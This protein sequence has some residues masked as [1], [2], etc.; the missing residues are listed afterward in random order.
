MSST[1]LKANYEGLLI[2]L[3]GFRK[4]WK[5]RWFRLVG[6]RLSYYASR[7]SYLTGSSPKG[8]VDLT[9]ESQVH[10][11]VGSY[12]ADHKALQRLSSD[13]HPFLMALQ[14]GSRK[15]TYFLAASSAGESHSWLE[16]LRAQ[17]DLART[18]LSSSSSSPSSSS[19]SSSSSTSSSSEKRNLLDA[20][21]A[22]LLKIAKN[23]PGMV[24]L[25]WKL[26][27]AE[28]GQ[29]LAEALSTNTTLRNL[30]LHGRGLNDQACTAI[31]KKLPHCARL[32]FLQLY[33]GQY[34][35][36]GLVALARVL[37][38]LPALTCLDIDQSTSHAAIHDGI[39]ALANTL[40][41]NKQLTRLRL[42]AMG[43]SDA[44]VAVIGEAI[45]ENATL[46]QL[47]LSANPFGEAGLQQLASDLK[48]NTTLSSLSLNNI[49]GPLTQ[50]FCEMCHTIS[51][52]PHLRRF[53]FNQNGLSL[54]HCMQFSQM[55][56]SPAVYLSE[57]VLDDTNLQNDE[58]SL[59]FA[60]LHCNLTLRKLSLRKNNISS[61]AD[62]IDMIQHNGFLETLDLSENPIGQVAE[63]TQLGIVLPQ[64]HSLRSLIFEG[65]SLISQDAVAQVLAALDWNL[66]L[67]SFTIALTDPQW[68]KARI[69]EHKGHN[70]ALPLRLLVVP[71]SSA[72]HAIGVG[73]QLPL[74]VRRPVIDVSGVDRI[75]Q[76]NAA[77]DR[78]TLNPLVVSGPMSGGLVSNDNRNLV[79]RDGTILN[80]DRLPFSCGEVESMLQPYIQ[81]G[82]NRVKQISF[83]G[84]KQLRSVPESL[85]AYPQLLS[86]CLAQA[87]LTSFLSPL[88]RQ[89]PNLVYLDLR[90]NEILELGDDLQHATKLQKL[91]V[92]SNQLASLPECIFGLR[93]A[94]LGSFKTLSTRQN[95][96]KDPLLPILYDACVV[97]ELV[98]SGRDLICVPP[99]ILSML[100]LQVLDLSRNK[101]V[102]IPPA[103]GRLTNLS[104]LNLARNA[105][106]TLPWQLSHL[107]KLQELSLAKNPLEKLPGELRTMPTSHILAYLAAMEHGTEVNYRTKCIVVGNGNVGK[108]SLINALRLNFLVDDSDRR[109][110]FGRKKAS[111]ENLSREDISFHRSSAIKTIATDGVDI[112]SLNLTDSASEDH[113]E[114]LTYDFAGQEVYYSTHEFFMSENAVYLVAFNLLDD[115]AD[116]L[117]FITYWLSAVQTR[118][119]RAP[120]LIVGTHLDDERCTKESVLRQLD[121]L[122]AAFKSKFSHIAGYFP[123]SSADGRGIREISDR[124]VRVALTRPQMSKEMPR[125]FRVFEDQLHSLAL[126]RDPPLLSRAEF[127]TLASESGILHSQVPVL[128]SFLNL[129]G[130]VISFG[131]DC[132]FSE[133]KA[134]V[135]LNPQWL[136]Y[137]FRCLISLKQ[138]FVRKGILDHANL[139]HIFKP[140]HFPPQ[141]HPILMLLLT[142]FEIIVPFPE[143]NVKSLKSIN[144]TGT[145]TSSSSSDSMSDLSHLTSALSLVPCLLDERV[146]ALDEWT[147]STQQPALL[148]HL[149][150]MPF[151]MFP[152]LMVRLLSTFT[153]LHISRNYLHLQSSDSQILLVASPPH[154]TNA[155]LYVTIAP[156][157]DATVRSI[158]KLL[159][160]L[161][162]N[163]ENLQKS[164]YHLKICCSIPCPCPSCVRQYPSERLRDFLMGIPRVRQDDVCLNVASLERAAAYNQDQVTCPSGQPIAVSMIAPHIALQQFSSLIHDYADFQSSKL[165]GKGAYGMVYAGMLE[166][167]PVAIKQLI[168]GAESS[169]EDV[170]SA[171]TSSSQIA[172]SQSGEDEEDEDPWVK[173]FIEFRQEVSIMCELCHP[174]IVMLLAISLKPLSIVTELCQHGT[175]FEILSKGSEESAHPI[176]LLK[177]QLKMA[178][179]IATGMEYLHTRTPPVIHRDLKTAN[180]F[181]VSL[182]AEDAVCAKV[183]DFGLS[184]AGGGQAKGRTLENPLWLA[185]EIMREYEYTTKADVYSFGILLWEIIAP[186]QIP[187]SHLDFT[188]WYD[189]ETKILAG[190]RPIIPANCPVPIS[191]LMQ[192]CWQDNPDLRPNFTSVINQISHIATQFQIVLSSPTPVPSQSKHPKKLTNIFMPP[193]L[194]HIPF[195]EKKKKKL[196]INQN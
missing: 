20:E 36:A 115:F 167:K 11:A 101:L 196:S 92:D 125:I 48:A 63:M 62:V 18:S 85:S 135:I 42:T 159:S 45:R 35:T 164:W 172:S 8:Y 179:D 79:V 43:I 53:A 117:R 44:S 140:P 104:R 75:V 31:S 121:D 29:R 56:E 34:G 155:F 148:Y 182:D 95:P 16:H 106:N 69:Q 28:L 76:R 183:A 6:C 2:K 184:F 153:P 116:S 189:V 181:C 128:L 109:K 132:P 108:T 5:S 97:D 27:Y 39:R 154:H 194:S 133:L 59:L 14:V 151:G 165:L 9:A 171:G 64:N 68:V 10:Q 37:N 129:T 166:G 175:L 26:P 186:G 174:N 138:S 110:L 150:F 57:L 102:V 127:T 21:Q 188:F 185:V 30:R 178:L 82:C 91:Y 142:Q 103:L 119:R 47:N 111:E 114:L 118:A 187:F 195:A 98:L 66:G 1:N 136:A 50:S 124:L 83:F 78:T 73:S 22:T 163:L 86:L 162:S 81:T 152:K 169:S 190:E 96:L 88:F 113:V 84:C 94:S 40:K 192:I 70:R 112:S 105:L 99:P 46:T 23:D 32:E 49:G 173:I 3:G 93:S 137:L 176:N 131:E 54:D 191:D 7:E 80:F 156:A 141:L 67:T 65:E 87:G 180:V 193:Q 177:L 123:V 77:F 143:A 130:A 126:T 146:H 157:K 55:L 168:G 38:R 100:H 107:T 145:S 24:S 71:T 61:L 4:N 149:D 72:A 161:R 52:N 25:S 158:A 15:R 139:I 122:R 90:W 33:K 147:W 60:A 58:A 160:E 41:T 12:A 170:L 144:H 74:A 134:L 89:L 120:V 17:I 51:L 13:M 19:S